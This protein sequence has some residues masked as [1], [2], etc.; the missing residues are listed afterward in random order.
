M[1]GH[2]QRI[3]LRHHGEI[4]DRYPR[5]V[6]LKWMPVAAFVVGVP[7]AVESAGEQELGVLPVLAHREAG[8]VAGQ[9]VHDLPPVLAIVVGHI[10]IGCVVVDPVAVRGEVS[11]AGFER[12]GSDDV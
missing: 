7:G 11:A 6:L 1:G 8:G 12:E 10:Y 3:L 5:Q 4:R 9:A 2:R